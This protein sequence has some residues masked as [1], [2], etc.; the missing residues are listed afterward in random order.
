[1]TSKEP[2]KAALTLDFCH[3]FACHSAGDLSADEMPLFLAAD[4]VQGVVSIDY[5]AASPASYN[6]DILKLCLYGIH[7]L[8]FI[9]IQDEYSYIVL[10]KLFIRMAAEKGSAG[11]PRV[12]VVRMPVRVTHQIV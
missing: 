11:T 4:G 8:D 10:G 2:P 1:M 6:D 5:S 7:S 9:I 12:S 3:S